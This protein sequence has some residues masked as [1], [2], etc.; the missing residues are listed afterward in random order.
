MEYEGIY[1]IYEKGKKDAEPIREDILLDTSDL[2]EAN[3][4]GDDILDMMDEDVSDAEDE[5]GDEPGT[6]AAGGG[7]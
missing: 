5:A 4:L 3:E 7:D 1:S 2:E 6:I